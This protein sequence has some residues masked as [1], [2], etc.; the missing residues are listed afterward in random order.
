MPGFSR[1]T[2]SVGVRLP[3]D[4]VA[5]L[6]ARLAKSKHK[7]LSAYLGARITYDVRRRHGKRTNG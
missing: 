1:I 7:T 5:I 2:A 6:K 4:V 3:L